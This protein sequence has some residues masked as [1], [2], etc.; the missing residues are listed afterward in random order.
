MINRK[1]LRNRIDAEPSKSGFVRWFERELIATNC[2]LSDAYCR[3]LI[4]P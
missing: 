4:N 1:I 3:F 2:D